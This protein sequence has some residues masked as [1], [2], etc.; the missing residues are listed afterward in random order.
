MGRWVA[1]AVVGTV[2]MAGCGGSSHKTASTASAA[3][4]AQPGATGAIPPNAPPG[5]RAI[6]GRVLRAGDLSGFAPQGRR[7]L[8]INVESWVAEEGLPPGE[9]TAEKA[10]L[11]SLGFISGVRERLAPS[12][13]APGE[14]ISIVVRFRTPVAARTDLAREV[15]MGQARGAAPFAVSAIPGARGFGGSTGGNTGYNVAFADADYYYL[16][17]AGFPAGSPGAPSRGALVL[18]AQRLYARVRR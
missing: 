10:R 17:G 18:A 8:G 7:T 15:Q 1:A 13:V 2:A 11:N 9:A 3:A 6:A 5:L 12:G 16:V 4:G 14:A